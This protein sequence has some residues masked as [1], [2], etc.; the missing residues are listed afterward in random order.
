[1][2]QVLDSMSSC[3]E[4]CLMILA[5]AVVVGLEMQRG[6][7]GMAFQRTVKKYMPE[8]IGLVVLALI[9]GILRIKGPSAAPL[10]DEAWNEIV[11]QWPCLM[12][13][14]TLLGLQAML[15]FLCF[16][17]ALLRL[18]SAEGAS[19]LAKETSAFFLAA[20]SVRAGLFWYS[21]AYHL[22]GPV[23][24]YIT[25]GFELATLLPLT[26]LVFSSG[27]WTWKAFFFISATIAASAYPA[28]C[29]AWRCAQLFL[30]CCMLETLP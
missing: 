2:A 30:I 19:A 12:T 11:N 14:D 26:A 29:I 9:A 18:G 23:G 22:D 27:E 16:N 17:S 28:W 6:S 20:M 1:M 5:A 25:G 4:A 15:R 24:G 21:A 10:D 8:T 7:R 3:I 13:A